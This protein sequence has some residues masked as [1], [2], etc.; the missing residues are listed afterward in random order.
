M[1][2]ALAYFDEE[3][4]DRSFLATVMEYNN[5]LPPV[6]RDVM[7][8]AQSVLLPRRRSLD[9]DLCLQLVNLLW[10][11]H[12]TLLEQGYH[13]KETL[14]QFIET[15]DSDERAALGHLLR[16][17]APSVAGTPLSQVLNLL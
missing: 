4:I 5:G 1:T 9:P 6:Q 12:G 3:V 11:H 10:E 13:I 16:A 17:Q 15:S 7:A 2:H 8:K 14:K